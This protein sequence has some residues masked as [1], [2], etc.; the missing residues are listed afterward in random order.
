VLLE[1]TPV[2]IIEDEVCSSNRVGTDTK[3]L[4]GTYMNTPQLTELIE[5]FVLLVK[6]SAPG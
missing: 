3:A 4:P 5:D 6:V 2:D 1:L